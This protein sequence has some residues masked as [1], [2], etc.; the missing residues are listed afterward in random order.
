MKE[1]DKDVTYRV[2]KSILDKMTD[3]QLDQKAQVMV[4]QV[5]G[6]ESIPLHP[7]IGFNTVGVYV[8]ADGVE[9]DT[10]RNAVD[11]KHHSEQ[12]VFLVDWNMFAED[13][14]IAFDLETGERLYGAEVENEF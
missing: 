12:F 13:G 11:N 3:K 10:T 2:I 7:V 4:P 1:E 6:D 9:V 14:A 8:S 5:N